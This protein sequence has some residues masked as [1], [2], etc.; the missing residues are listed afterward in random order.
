MEVVGSMWKI[1][2]GNDSRAAFKWHFVFRNQSFLQT[3]WRLKKQ[4]RSTLPQQFDD[5]FMWYQTSR[6]AWQENQRTKEKTTKHHVG[7]FERKNA[8]QISSL[9]SLRT[10]QHKGISPQ[11]KMS[12]IWQNMG[13]AEWKF[14]SW[15]DQGSA[16][17]I[18]ITMHVR[19][20]PPGWQVECRRRWC[21]CYH[22][23]QL[24]LA[25]SSARHSIPNVEKVLHNCLHTSNASK[26]HACMLPNCMQ[27]TSAFQTTN[28][29][30][31][32]KQYKNKQFHIKQ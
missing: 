17:D 4:T 18:N 5:I 13:C 6:I 27:K 2:I 22:R 12:R 20:D 11:T 29:I 16:R 10:L 8:C 31:L 9:T 21:T 23:T 3:S 24:S 32:L 7:K 14:C 15:G 19:H 30:F 28:P 25:S 26:Q 1:R